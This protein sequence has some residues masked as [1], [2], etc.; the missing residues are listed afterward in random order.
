MSGRK[1]F[2]KIRECSGRLWETLGWLW[3]AL[4]GS[5]GLLHGCIRPAAGL[6]QGEGEDEGKAQRGPAAASV[7][8][9][10]APRGESIRSGWLMIAHLMGGAEK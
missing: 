3:E 6:L 9:R 1:Q 7:G 5:A 4:G 8:P 10:E 2:L